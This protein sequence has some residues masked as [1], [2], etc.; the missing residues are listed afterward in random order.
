MCGLCE[1]ELELIMMSHFKARLVGLGNKQEYG[2]DYDETF[3]PISKMTYVRTILSIATSNRWFLHQI[4]V[5]NAFLHGDLTTSTGIA[6]FLLYVDDMIIIGYDHASIQSLKQQLQAPLH[7]KDLVDTPLKV[8][9]KYH[10]DD[11]DLL[12]DPL[13]YRQLVGSLNHFTI[14]FPDISFVVKQVSQF[15]HSPLHL[16]LEVF[17]C[18]ILYLNGSS[19]RGLFFPTGIF[20]K[21]SAFNDVDWAGCPDTPRSVTGWCMFL[22]SSLIS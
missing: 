16:H 17:R 9:V 5:K 7:M 2:V 6:L 19:H 11:G 10:R 21:L 22:G 1:I 8:N 14:T 18:I 20:P 3:A 15:M 13:L 12:P 4:D